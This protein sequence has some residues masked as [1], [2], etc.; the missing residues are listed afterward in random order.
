MALWTRLHELDAVSERVGRVH[1]S[2]ACQGLGFDDLDPSVPQPRD[3]RGEIANAQPGVRLARRPEVGIDPEV[4][5][6]CPGLEPHAAAA[7]EV[8]G[9]RDLGDAQEPRIESTGGLLL[10]GRHRKLNVVDRLDVHGSSSILA[11]WESSNDSA[12]ARR[13]ISNPRGGRLTS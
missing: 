11:T 5:L 12:A 9:L 7:R 3:E 2:V 13:E 10:A 4:N 8:R 6:E 1:V